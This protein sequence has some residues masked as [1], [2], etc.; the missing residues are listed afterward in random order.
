MMNYID[1]TLKFIESDEMREYMHTYLHGLQDDKKTGWLRNTCAEIVSNAPACIERKIPVLDLIAEQTEPIPK[2]DWHDPVWLAEFARRALGEEQKGQVGTVFQVRE[3]LYHE[4]GNY[5]DYTLYHTFDAAID[6]IKWI[7]SECDNRDPDYIN[8][9]AYYYIEKFIPGDDGKM[10]ATF[11]W[12]INHSGE[13]WYFGEERY[14]CDPFR[15]KFF[16]FLGNLNLPV[17]FEPGDIVTADCRPFAKDRR[18][19]ILKVGDNS[20]CCCVQCLFILPTGKLDTGAFKHNRFFRSAHHEI[21]H[22]SSLYR[23][24]RYEG[25]LDENEQP[26]IELSAAIGENH[27]LGSEIW[28]YF[29]ENDD[30]WGI[31]WEKIKNNFVK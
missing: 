30:G 29:F 16:D 20:D 14:T 2:G 31:P 6:Y 13:I 21:S 19:L 11:Y 7:D 3:Y 28:D 8:D 18:V 12:I 24:V 22:V 25:E 23:A 17:P 26:F 15:D 4:P 27:H 9:I 5:D 10:V 1:E